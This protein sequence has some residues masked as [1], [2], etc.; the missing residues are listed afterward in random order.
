MCKILLL[1]ECFYHFFGFQ[2]IRTL[3]SNTFEE[4]TT[5]AMHEKRKKT[6]SSVLYF[7]KFY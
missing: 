1:I 6:T 2:R 5:I 4:N 3:T 7:L